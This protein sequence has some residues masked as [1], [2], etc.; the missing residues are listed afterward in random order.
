MY[1]LGKR[2]G[3]Q[4]FSEFIASDDELAVLMRFKALGAQPLYLQSEMME[5]GHS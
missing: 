4:G 2:R 5:L 1:A 3:H